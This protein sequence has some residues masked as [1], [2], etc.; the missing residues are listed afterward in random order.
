MQYTPASEQLKQRHW[1]MAALVSVT[2]A[3]TGDIFSLGVFH[4]YYPAYHPLTDPISALGANTSPISAAVSAWWIFLGCVFLFFALAYRAGRSSNRIV[5]LLIVLYAVCEELGSGL[6]PGNH[7]DH[8]LTLTGWIHNVLGAFGVAGLAA[9]PF[10][11]MRDSLVRKRKP[12]LQFLKFASATGV[13]FFLLFSVSRLSTPSLALLRSYH[14]LWQRLFVA[15]Y[16][17]ILVV[18]AAFQ[19]KNTPGIPS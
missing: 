11:L 14:G 7:L 3:T 5:F 17:V 12:F 2:F 13:L 19:L 6:F 4:R 8:H 15:N 10:V 16:Y 1:A 9:V 18:L